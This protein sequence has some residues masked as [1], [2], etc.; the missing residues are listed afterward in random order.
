[1][2]FGAGFAFMPLAGKSVLCLCVASQDWS[3]CSTSIESCPPAYP[4]YFTLTNSLNLSRVSFSTFTW[5]CAFGKLK[6]S[7]MQE[8]VHMY[9]SM[10][11]CTQLCYSK[12]LK[13]RVLVVFEPR[14]FVDLLS[15]LTS[16]FAFCTQTW[17][18]NFALSSLPAIDHRS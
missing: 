8:R 10:Y 18:T 5:S 12:R 4:S 9:Q 2:D 11:I 14:S 15:F 3:T 7:S 13:D 16:E 17:H 1:M 6:L